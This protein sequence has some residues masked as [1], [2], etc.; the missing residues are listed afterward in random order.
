MNVH[1]YNNKDVPNKINKSIGSA[2]IIENVRF[3]ENN[4]LDVTNPSILLNMVDNL[5]DFTQFNY[6]YIP[7]FKRYYFVT[8]ISFENGLV[9]FDCKCDVLYTFRDDINK[10][11]QYITRSESKQNKFIVDS[12]LPIQSYNTYDVIKFPN[13]VDDRQNIYVILETVGRGGQSV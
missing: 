11:S 10:S 13:A 8:K 7:K 12:L 3:V 4:S 5:D 1:L 9:R 2:T 6:C